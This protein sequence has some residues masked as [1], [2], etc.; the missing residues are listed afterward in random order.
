MCSG[1]AIRRPLRG[2]KRWRAPPV[3]EHHG[4]DIVRPGLRGA[5]PQLVDESAFDPGRLTVEVTESGL[6]EDLNAAAHLLAGCAKGGL[7]VAI[8]DFGTGYSSLLI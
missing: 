1:K 5:I 4:G 2:P 8:D 7:R 3:G 6:I